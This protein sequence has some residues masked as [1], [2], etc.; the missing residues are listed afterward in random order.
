V[1]ENL[2]RSIFLLEL[3]EEIIMAK[4]TL[5]NISS[6][7]VVVGTSDGTM[8]SRSLAPNRVITLTPTEYEDLMYEPGVQNMIRGGYIKIDGVAEDRAVIETPTNV[9]SRD[10]IIKML[11]DRD[12]T[13]FANYIKIAPSAAKDT[14]VQY[15][16]DNNITDNAFT[17][18]IKK[19]C[20]I[21]VIQAISVKH[22]AE[23]K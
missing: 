2:A 4:I 14:I 17:A 15:V 10:E 3:K 5:K 8:R 13:A 11:N 19:Y 18:L 23:E 16:V 12:I 20:G 9:M 22:Q 7:T 1:G 6:A 21:D